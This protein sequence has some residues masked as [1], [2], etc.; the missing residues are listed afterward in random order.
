[1]SRDDKHRVLVP[2]MPQLYEGAPVGRSGNGRSRRVHSGG[3]KATHRIETAVSY[4]TTI[5]VPSPSDPAA[6]PV[7]TRPPC[8]AGGLSSVVS[9]RVS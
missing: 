4:P 1:M 5:R 8:R 3:R 6:D 9:L 7:H 2:I